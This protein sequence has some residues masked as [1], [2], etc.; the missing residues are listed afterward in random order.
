MNLDYIPSWLNDTYTLLQ[1]LQKCIEKIENISLKEI[2][3]AIKP[4]QTEIDSIT[5]DIAALSTTANNAM[6]LAKTNETDIATLDG[7]VASLETDCA[8]VNKTNTFTKPQ[9]IR[10]DTYTSL[11]MIIQEGTVSE[12]D[13]TDYS[14]GHI[15]KSKNNKRQIYTYNLPDK[16]GDMALKSD[17]PT[18]GVVNGQEEIYAGEGD[19]S[20]VR[21]HAGSSPSDAYL[22]IVGGSGAYP[23]RIYPMKSGAHNQVDYILP[24]TNN[25]SDTP[26]E[27]HLL[28]DKNV[29]T[30]F[31]N[32]SIFGSGNIDL[33][34]HDIKVAFSGSEFASGASVH[35]I[36]NSSK[37]TVVDSLTDLKTLLGNTF[38]V[39]IFGEVFHNDETEAT[40]ATPYIPLYADQN[41]LYFSDNGAW[42]AVPFGSQEYMPQIS[43]TV[44]TV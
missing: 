33:Y 44:T 42:V 36:V 22:E 28:S 17:I 1:K 30:L 12:Y 4:I 23:S 14:H 7:Q 9:V 10:R 29:K 26:E 24:D 39:D 8:F 21:M 31:G 41:G 20:Q 15:T 40:H 38:T 43:D 32:K 19:P 6:S 13:Y 5:A 2:P 35:I 25:T 3:D 11:G 18:N 27:Q 16:S 34:K 37:N